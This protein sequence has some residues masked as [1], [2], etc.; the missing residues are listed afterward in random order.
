[1]PGGRFGQAGGGQDM[2]P[3][4][5]LLLF[6]VKPPF[7]EDTKTG[8]YVLQNLVWLLGSL[9]GSM[10]V[11]F[12]G[13]V[14]RFGGF[15][16]ESLAWCCAGMSADFCGGVAC[17]CGCLA[18]VIRLCWFREVVRFSLEH[19]RT[20]KPFMFFGS[21]VYLC[22]DSLGWHLFCPLV[23]AI[24]VKGRPEPSGGLRMGVFWRKKVLAA[25]R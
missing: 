25:W 7:E 21:P 12:L 23:G 9:L 2:D 6:F 22:L 8:P 1:M 18:V 10:L 24:R 11:Y 16:G 13:G 19:A 14:T 4:G 17:V 3:V 15:F 5:T 20:V